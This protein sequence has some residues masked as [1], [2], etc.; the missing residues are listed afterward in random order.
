[1]LKNYFKSS[2]RNLIRHKGYSF[3]NIFG[4]TVGLATSIFIF[5]WVMDEVSYDRFHKNRERIYRVM[6][7]HNYTDDKIET[8]WSTPPPL[9]EALHTEVPEIEYTMR[10]TWNIGKLLR[11]G[12]K[13]FYESGYYADS[14]LFKIFTFP[15]IYGDPNNPLP[16]VT[17]VAISEKLAKKYL[18]NEN[19]IGKVLRF[20]QSVDLKVTAVFADIP[21]NSSLKFDF[22]VP[23]QVWEKEHT[24]MQWV[25]NGM[26][27]FVSLK[28]HA[29]LERANK[30][31]NGIVKKHCSD[32]RSEPFL[33]PYADLRLYS[34]FE[35]GQRAGGRIDYV[36]AFSLVAFIILF[37][38]CINFMNLATARST[39]RS[40]EVGIRKVIGAQRTGLVS[41]FIG[42]SIFLS[43]I[44][45]VCALAL[46]QILL[47]FFNSLTTKTVCI[48]FLDPWLVTGLLAIT[49]FCGLLAGSYPAFFLSSFK[50]VIVLK[51]GAPSAL[52]G[53]GLRKSLVIL[54]FAV[55]II[56]IVGS[57]VVY[58]QIS[59][60]QNKHLGFDKENILLLDQFEGAYK[61]QEAYKNELLLHPAIKSAGSAGH[62]PFDI[63]V[64]TTD[65]V[66]PGKSTGTEISFK[67]LQCD[68]DFLATMGMEILHGRNFSDNYKMDSANYII[69][70]K[71]M[72]I[73]GLDREN[74]LGTDLDMWSRK[75][76]I[77]GVI[78]DFNNVNLR[79]AIEPLVAV[80]R[81]ENTTRI[82]VKVEGDVASALD[83]IKK[84]QEKYDPG[85]PFEYDF[86]DQ[87]F[88]AQYGNEKV[89]GELSLI[90]TVVAILI[91]CLGLFGLASFTAERKLKELGIRKVLGASALNLIVMLCGDFAKLVTIGLI[92]GCP[93][94]WYLASEYLS[95]YAF[96]SELNV[97]IFLITSAAVLFIALLTVMYQS[98][99]AA[100]TNPINS[101]RNE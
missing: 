12:E 88:D 51:G 34:E 43:F 38:A 21:Q 92:I 89:V 78:R 72:A 7:N 35:N 82:F 74:V 66:W 94:A 67:V 32:C 27:T 76:K 49:L 48:N 71:A 14:T 8:G 87:K 50:P 41:H 100:M 3:I 31:V 77:I 25:N 75:G 33:F 42:E 37:I 53:G 6:N 90:F 56:L 91:S 65:P 10:I 11:Y 69:N 44:A 63:Q 20:S 101:L 23:Y 61:N 95:G 84:V 60:I 85:Y 26:Q 36:I 30:K 54:Q 93:A 24:W 57:I 19:P 47:P 73:M 64:A 58:N 16:D 83:H 97:W 4:L 17:S 28:P 59:Y 86:L 2:L 99:R 79:Q 45:L 40:R 1:M 80:Y 15:I 96:R 62:N 39:T 9:A 13:A 52:S 68:Q 46:V 18:N 29:S 81:P 98:A 22:I 5:L 55:S 70:E